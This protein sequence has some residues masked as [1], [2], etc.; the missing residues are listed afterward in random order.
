MEK[1]HTHPNIAPLGVINETQ[2]E[3]NE[4]CVSVTCCDL[5]DITATHDHSGH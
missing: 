5:G 3:M 2:C 1:V 4:T